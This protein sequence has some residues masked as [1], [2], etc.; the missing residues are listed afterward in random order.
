MCI[1]AFSYQ[2]PAGVLLSLWANRDEW[3]DRKSQKADFWEENKEVWGGKDLKEGGSW[4]AVD[5]NGRFAFLTNYRNLY[6]GSVSASRSRGHLVR[7]FLLGGKSP[8]EYAD[9]IRSFRDEMEGYNL[10]WGDG[11]E[12]FYYNNRKDLFFPILPGV[13]T[14]SNGL[15]D[16]AWPKTIRLRKAFLESL[17]D[18]SPQWVEAGLKALSDRTKALPWQLPNTGIG[19][20]KEWALSSIFIDVPGYGTR[21]STT[22][23][24]PQNS[25]EIRIFYEKNWDF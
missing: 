20:W 23:R 21:S 10:V 4:L 12:A 15:L 22:L 17:T 9:Q 19:F 7:D 2:F 8:Q 1:V 14:L 3:K 18:F 5:R 11:Q 25:P 24:L 16:E 6:L 13:H